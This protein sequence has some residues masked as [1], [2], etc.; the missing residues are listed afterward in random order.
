MTMQSDGVALEIPD[1]RSA[2]AEDMRRY[3][4]A[5]Q[6]FVRN[7]EARLPAV[8]D[9]TEHNRMVDYLHTLADE[10][11][12]QL[13]IFREIE[14][15]RVDHLQCLLGMLVAEAIG[16]SERRRYHPPRRPVS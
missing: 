11:N 9:A 14:Q 12:R 3:G 5:L 10:Y 1:G 7:T 13:R 16:E 8:A 6:Q 2:S 15:Q 4:Q